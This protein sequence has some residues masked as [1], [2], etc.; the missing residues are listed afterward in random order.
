MSSLDIFLK[1][2]AFYDSL[3]IRGLAE[4]VVISK[5][6]VAEFLKRLIKIGL[7]YSNPLIHH[8]SH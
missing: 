8:L 3:S 6:E 7:S 2:S 1:L 4:A 5:S